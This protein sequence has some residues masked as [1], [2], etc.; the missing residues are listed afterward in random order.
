MKL[1]QGGSSAPLSR[2]TITQIE[3]DSDAYA[4]ELDLRFRVLRQPLG[5]DRSTVPSAIEGDAWHIVARDHAGTVVGCV[6]FVQDAV[7]GGRLLQMAVDPALQGLGV[8]RMLVRHL[9]TQVA[10][11]GLRAI[12]LHARDSAIGFYHSLGY[13]VFGDPFVEVGLGHHMMRRTLDTAE[14][15]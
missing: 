1:Q 2:L 3:R 10:A 13:A 11:A 8:G 9:E 12:H 14:T 6:L 15:A 7:D 5:M 4:G